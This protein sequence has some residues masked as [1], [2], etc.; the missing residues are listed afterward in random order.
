MK[1]NRLQSPDIVYAELF[2]AVQRQWGVGHSKVFID[3]LPKRTPVNIL[4]AYRRTNQDSSFDLTEFVQ[5]NFDLPQEED[6]ALIES[7]NLSV[8]EYIEA[9]WVHLERSTDQREK[10]SSLLELPYPYIV[11]GGRFREIYYWDSYFTMLGLAQSGHHELVQSMVDN[12]AFLIDQVGFIPNGNRT[13]YCSRSQPPFF[14]LMVELLA[15]ITQSHDEVYLKYLPHL[16]QEYDFWMLGCDELI[17]DRQA[18]RRVIRV[19]D[20]YLNRF[21]D[22]LDKPRPESYLEDIEMAAAADRDPAGLY[23]DIRAAAESGWDF[24]ARWFADGKNMI[25]ICTTEVVPVDLNSL[26]YHLET[27]LAESYRCV[28]DAEQQAQFERRA[29]ARRKLLETIFF[30]PQKHTFCDLLLPDLRPSPVLSLAGVFP[31]YFG[32]ATTDQARQVKQKL[33]AEFLRKG[34]WV[35]VLC[36]TGQQWDAPNGWAPLQWIV[37]QGLNSYGYLNE[38]KEGAQR[39]VDNNLLTYKKTGTLLEKY[40]V[41]IPNELA[42]G[43]EYEVQRGFGWTNGV[44][45]SL[46]NQL[47]V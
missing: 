2:D 42:G 33:Q 36:S 41:E 6:T 9:M 30:N 20:A 35:N 7:K 21:W 43:G 38:A 16:R 24:S 40:N 10:H 46:M 39:W 44:L 34:G 27:L 25:S 18:S 3:A 45:L 19:G 15:D 28:S 11:P 8:R 31:L 29:E 22:D 4:Q 12:F 47:K 23:R 5:A 13:Y 1:L 32:I 17:E 37:Y 14:A 26:M